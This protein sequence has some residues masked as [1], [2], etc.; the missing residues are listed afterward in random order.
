MT[1]RV[2]SGLDDLP[3]AYAALFARAGAGRFQLGLPWFRNLSA[4]AADAGDAIRVYGVEG[5]PKEG[6]AG[7]ALA[8]VARV[9]GRNGAGRKLAGF[10]SPYTTEFDLVADQP[11]AAAI[12][13]LAAALA[14]ERPRWDAIE[15]GALPAASPGFGKLVGGLWD[16]GFAVRPHFHFGQWFEP[17]AGD[18][19][20]AYLA[21]RPG[22]LRNTLKRHQNKAAREAKLEFTLVTAAA[23][24]PAAVADYEAIYA[25]SW[26]E[27]EPHPRFIGGLARAAAEAG[28]LRLGVLR[29]NGAPAAAQLWLVAGGR[30]TIFKLAHDERW[31]P[32]SPGTLL[33]ARMLEYALD[34][35]R[36]AEIDY[37]RGDDDYKKLW[38]TERR[39][40]W[41]IAAYNRRTARGLA[42]ALRHVALPKLA[43]R[44]AGAPAP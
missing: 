38:L 29:L 23:E 12:A 40:C 21:R 17:T 7:P 43:G 34:V 15:L 20:A 2:F 33:T 27:P 22:Q 26:K 4:T 31:K 8:L 30:A 19:Y 41:G 18:S 13:E 5:G 14:A 44:L 36:V 32:F 25:T 16:A 37:G 35:D 6:G 3:P 9:P 24:V 42:G 10:V 11:D 39:E 1:V 28:A